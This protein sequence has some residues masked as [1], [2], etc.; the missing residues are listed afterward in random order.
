MKITAVR[1]VQLTRRLERTQRN[2]CQ[3]RDAR[4]F[5][6]VLV[7]T[8]AGLTGLGDA[9]GDPLLV[10]TIVQRRLGPMAIG[11]DPCDIPALWKRLF[12]SR[13]FWEPGGSVVCGISAIEVACWDIRG[14]AR[15]S[16]RL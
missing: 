15:G 3:Q 9:F 16:R 11:A 13:A 10:E 5:T 8:D 7:D 2:S 4:K 14:Q 1:T 12:A 6:F